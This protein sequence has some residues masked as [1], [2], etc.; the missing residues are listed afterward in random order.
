MS[1]V[2]ILLG[3]TAVQVSLP[4]ALAVG[5][6]GASAALA[7]Q[8][9]E[10]TLPGGAGT[11][12]AKEHAA[13][14]AGSAA[15]AAAA[16]VWAEGTLPGGPGTKSAKEHAID[17]GT[18]GAAQVALAAA[19]VALAAGEADR[20]QDAAANIG[21]VVTESLYQ[22]IGF[23]ANTVYP[24]NTSAGAQ[25]IYFLDQVA[26][27]GF[28]EGAVFANG[29]AG[30]LKFG[31]FRNISG[32]V[33]KISE[34]SV[35]G[36]AGGSETRKAVLASPLAVLT[37]DY[38]VLQGSV[39]GVLKLTNTAGDGLGVYVGSTGALPPTI[40]L[41]AASTIR[42]MATILIR[43]AAALAG[44]DNLEQVGFTAQNLATDVA[45][46]RV[47]VTEY[48]GRPIGNQMTAGSNVNT[49]KLFFLD[50]VPH[51]STLSSVRVY[52]KAAGTM[53]VAHYRLQGGFRTLVAQTTVTLT[54]A[55]VEADYALAAPLTLK[56]GDLLAVRCQTTGMLGCTLSGIDG[57]GVFAGT[58]GAFENV[59]VPGTATANFKPHLRFNLTYAQLQPP[60]R[61]S[62]TVAPVS[63]KA[64]V[65]TDGRSLTAWRAKAARKLSGTSTLLNVLMTG[66]SW[67]EY[68]AIPE[69]FAALLHAT[70]GKAGDG[71]ISVNNASTT[72]ALT[73]HHSRT[74]T[75]TK[76]NWTTYDAS[77][78][79]APGA[80][81][82]AL[83]GQ[84][85]STTGTTATL[86]IAGW[87]ATDFKL[88]YAKG[89]GSF[90]YRLDGGAWT[91]ITGDGSNTLGV[92]TLSG[93][94]ATSH[95]IEIDTTVNGGGTVAILGGAAW[96]SAGTG[97]IL[98]KAGN[99]GAVAS[100]M[101][102]FAASYIT[103]IAS[104][105][106]PDLV[107]VIMGT[108][109]CR[110]SGATPALMVTAYGQMV[111]AYRAANP[112]CGFVFVCPPRNGGTII[113]ELSFY[114][115]AVYD[116]CI[117]NGH[118]FLNWYDQCGTYANESANWV[119]TLHRNAAGGYQHASD[120]HRMQAL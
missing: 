117:S 48:I 17:A 76:A 68:P 72:N 21:A 105:L 26:H 111:T 102:L 40:T 18:N 88:F 66:D 41:G 25:A 116:F 118:E 24:S 80:F 59:A 84:A 28:L 8:W 71:F 96:N 110:T 65:R 1:T 33:T 95:S 89:T 13:A 55:A 29:A 60:Q 63:A 32:T 106:A 64:P 91:T 77:G 120:M 3:S 47:N 14:A 19:Q 12:S 9:A 35:T 37:G 83:D 2:S 49:A 98:S 38:I 15:T 34:G 82:C 52:D 70:Y 93:L 62:P 39:T 100:N 36:F 115:D 78:G 86:T 67:A 79:V 108:N 53:D 58:T 45:D 90:R 51:D 50:L 20:A 54:G 11:K 56:A 73:S 97:V 22:T 30:D 101:S 75:V 16:Q 87:T 114:R 94:S 61:R 43:Y 81:G 104:E 107:Y 27:A 6:A 92:V 31:V 44:N 119:D 103:P 85:I 109:D 46:A 4:G 42:P 23:P 5:A 7:Q 99:A 69:Q 112:N 57:N 113:T 10:G 74:V